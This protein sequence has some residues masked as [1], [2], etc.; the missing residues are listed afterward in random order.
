M[1]PSFKNRLFII[2]KRVSRIKIISIFL[3]IE[4]INLSSNYNN[5]ERFLICTSAVLALVIFIT[6][7]LLFPEGGFVY[8]EKEEAVIEEQQMEEKKTLL[9]HLILMV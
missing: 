2:N 9:Y 1:K 4:L 6:L 7:K 5:L 8:S 3:I